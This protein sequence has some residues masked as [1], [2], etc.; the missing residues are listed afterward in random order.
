MY[1]IDYINNLISKEVEESLKVE[2]KRSESIADR[3]EM[4]KDISAMANSAGGVIIYGIE[5]DNHRASSKSFING[6]EFSK[7][8]LEN[9]I[10]SN[11]YRKV[12]GLI[13]HPIRVDGK[14]EKSIYVI[15]VPESQD[16]PHMAKDKKYYKRHNFKNLPMEEYEVRSLYFKSRYPELMLDNILLSNNFYLESKNGDDYLYGSPKFQIYNKGK[17]VS[18]HHKI[19]LHIKREYKGSFSYDVIR[20]TNK[21]SESLLDDSTLLLTIYDRTPIMPRELVAIGRFDL[22]FPREFI[23]KNHNEEDESN[24]K[25]DLIYDGGRDT[26]DLKITDFYPRQ[27]VEEYL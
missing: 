5:E 16:S 2:F 3:K 6:Q 12:E 13:I 24:I 20:S 8:W 1:D 10:D 4:S 14:I 19:I 17:G 21:I 23:V 18:I 7:E 27:F 22:C 9:V 11:I 15:E 25:V 26:M